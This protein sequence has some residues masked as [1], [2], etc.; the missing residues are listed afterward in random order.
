MTRLSYQR[1]LQDM[2]A[3]QMNMIRCWG[4]GDYP[5]DVDDIADGL[6]ILVS[7]DLPF[8]CAPYSPVD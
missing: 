8:A 4:G 3:A 6:G 5:A 2:R 1:L 7:Q